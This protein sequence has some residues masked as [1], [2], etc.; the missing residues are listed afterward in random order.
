MNQ[1]R[2]QGFLQELPQMR[3]DLPFS[4]EVLRTLFVQT[5]GGSLASLED[6]GKTLG[7]D[8]G[9]TTRIL[10]LANSAYYGL[11][12]E[13]QSVPRAAAVLGM[14]EIRNIVLAL[15][16]NG[17]TRRYPIPEDFDLG[18]YWTHQFLVA[19]VAKELSDM[20]DVGKP[21]NLFTSGLLHDIG[22]LITALKRPDDWAAMREKAESDEMTDS[23]A[24]E[25][26]WGLDH[27][28]IGALVLRSWDLPATLV[29]PVNWH[30]S[31]DLSPEHS[32]ESNVICLAD[33]VT[34]AVTDPEGPYLERVEQLCQAVDVDMDD[35]MEVGEELL[36]SD[37]IEQFVNILS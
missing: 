19:M 17:L 6:V 4:P 32:T 1:D 5:G 27:A 35:I 22:K 15:G 14:A 16:V 28:V 7:Q 11:Q 9:L 26:Y 29:E 2:I 3:Q 23:E 18:E 20:T 34:H 36:D 31:P 25:D 30:H 12:A 10:S 37:D 13:V 21:D 8:Q 24:E 33:C